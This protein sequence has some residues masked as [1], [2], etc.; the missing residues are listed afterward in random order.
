AEQ[1]RNKETEARKN[2]AEAVAAKEEL[3]TTLARSLLR[4][5]AL[6]VQPN[7]AL[8][9]QRDSALPPLSD[10]EIDAVWEL[11]SGKEERLGVGFV[12]EAL[13]GPLQTRQLK[14]RVV[15]ALQAAV[16]L[17]E[18]RRTRVEELLGQAL[19]APGS[20]PEQQRDIALILAQ[21]GIQDPALAGKAA[22]TLTQ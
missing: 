15:Y 21:V 12:Q 8:L 13:R 18:G 19:Q 6:Q 2:E 17:D 10:P 7:Q 20:T 1:A 4:P 16:A 14:G 9:L 11:A 22:A 3:V 5:L